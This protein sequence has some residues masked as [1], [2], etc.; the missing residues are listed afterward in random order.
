MRFR[1]SM[2]LGALLVLSLVLPVHAKGPQAA[3]P[4]ASAEGISEYALDNGLRV[5]LFP[6]PS[7]PVT[8]V[9]VTYLVGSRHENYGETGMAHLLEH[10]V[11][12]GT[13]TH[14][15]ITGDLKKRGIRFNGTTWLDRTNYFAS[16]ATDPATL[17]WLLQ[18]EADR[19]VHS[20]ISRKDLDSEMTVVRNEMESGENNPFRILL[21]RLMS[22]AYIWHNYGNST[23]GARADV[24]NVP[25][26]RLQAFYRNFYQPDNAVL[27]IA[28][29]FDPEATLTLVAD[30]FGKLA[31]P[32]RK[33]QDTYTR[34]PAQDG[35]RSV[36]I[37]RVGKTP[38]LALGYHMP[39][40][41][42]A[43]SAALSV[44]GEVLGHTPN[45]RLHKA[46][47]DAGKATSVANIEFAMDEPGYFMVFAEA[48][49]ESDLDALEASMVDIVE[50]SARKPITE[51]EVAEARQRMLTNYE[52]SMRDPNA[53]GVALSEA[54]AQ[55]DWRLF[56]LGRDRVEQVTLADVARVAATYLK[57]ENRST[58]RFIPTDKPDRV[59]IAEAP[60]AA[61]L[62]KDYVG[63]E[64]VAAG[65]AFDPSPANIDQRTQSFTLDNKAELSVLSKSTRGRSVQLRI[66]LRLGDEA[67]LTDRDTAASLLADMLMRGT[68]GLDRSAISSRLVAL[69]SELDIG[70][71]PTQVSVVANTDHDNFP[72]LLELVATLLKQPTLP[73]NEFA[74]LRTQAITDLRSSMTE[75][76]AIAS[77]AMG[78]YYNRWPK[79]HP[80]YATTVEED[81]AALQAV[82]L[83]DLRA[84]HSSFYGA[85]GASIAVIGDVDAAQVQAQVA[86]LFGDWNAAKAFTRI[87]SPYYGKP[88]VREAIE[89][90]DKPNAMFLATLP[91]PVGQDH[92][93]YPALVLG[94]YILG[95]GSLK[96]R[97]ADRIRQRE[98][99]SYGV[100]SSFS[101]SAIDE[102]GSFFAYAIAAPENVAK[103]E[104]AFREEVAKI[105][106]EGVTQTEF[107]E[108]LDGMLKARRTSR[109]N[110][111][112]LVALLASN[113]YLDRTMADAAKFEADL[114]AQTPD[115]VRAAL[116]RHLK[117]AEISVF[118]AG[119]FVGA[120]SRAGGKPATEGGTR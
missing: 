114:R 4:V 82:K 88:A 98:G 45:G 25:I 94:N 85:A 7:K 49:A 18:M 95:G 36:S 38:Y 17:Q 11:F 19:M 81:L 23:I 97:L 100:G 118:A 116:A 102:S 113:L 51:A 70:G 108:A 77:R 69:K 43:D 40:S 20:H 92:A 107:D 26:E 84:F 61:T 67:S 89:T 59:T 103:V 1:H 21:Q 63:K 34:E 54:I 120:A 83:D 66:D 10:L 37:R 73:D 27:V 79:G 65:E 5:V 105:V 64:A 75:P 39:A 41:R 72:A 46:L 6:D 86:R 57:P 56:L 104:A 106:A 78:R 74:Q 29:D 99:L 62:L 30:S 24:E 110:D 32:T 119:D 52:V 48:P 71:G 111:G 91:M 90:P 115:S 117:P 8:T 28:G 13:P 53:I 9:N 35:Q 12:K 60:S 16:F 80:Y 14:P 58:G 112:E 15:D 101:A 93:D 31:R 33:L 22:T 96:S 68:Q 109:A 3:T 44:L 47:V 50:H 55:G 76:N 42:H 87:P 2:G